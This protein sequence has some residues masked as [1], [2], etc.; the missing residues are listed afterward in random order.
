MQDLARRRL[1]N[2]GQH[3]SIASLGAGGHSRLGQAGGAS[4]EESIRLV[5]EALDLGISMVDTAP[6]YGTE[7]IVG[8]ALAHAP[9]AAVSTKAAVVGADGAPVTAAQLRAS[10]EGSLTKLR[11]E[12]VDVFYLHGVAPN[13]YRRCREDLIPEML[14]LR[15]EGKLAAI[16][17][18]ERFASDPGHVMLREAAADPVW[19]VLMVGANYLN[20]TAV[21]AVIGPAASRGIGIV[22]MYALR[23]SLANADFMDALVCDLVR[24]GEVTSYADW[25]ALLARLPS[26]APGLPNL[27]DMA[28]RFCS[29]IRGV[30]TVLT[31]SGNSRHLVD[32]VRSIAGR[33]LQPDL[34]KQLRRLFGRVQTESG[35]VDDVAVRGEAR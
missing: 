17:I 15:R 12:R 29:H 28:Y 16:G 26:G 19:D 10:L 24:R 32:N 4:F 33:P 25:Q 18:T 20:Q 3:V 14:R 34:L 2:T 9:D 7:E 27:A 23:G 30:S 21:D 31:G 1:G 11:R 35:E 22:C 6:A 8:V 13:H 5:R